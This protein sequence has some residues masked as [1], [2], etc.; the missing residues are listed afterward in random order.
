MSSFTTNL[1]RKALCAGEGAWE[2]R[3][4]SWDTSLGREYKKQDLD[5]T[6]AKCLGG[7]LRAVAALDLM[8]RSSLRSFSLDCQSNPAPIRRESGELPQGDPPPN[9][10]SQT[11][12]SR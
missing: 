8:R 3:L 5:A 11:V 12:G 6:S 7:L 9:A 10:G 4:P 2:S 1:S